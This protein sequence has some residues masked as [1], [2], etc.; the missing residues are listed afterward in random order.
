[1]VNSYNYKLS[2]YYKPTLFRVDG[3]KIAHGLIIRTIRY[4][5]MYNAFITCP[6]HPLYVRMMGLGLHRGSTSSL[7]VVRGIV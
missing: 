7:D 5:H 3:R 2:T 1:M 4:M 6:L